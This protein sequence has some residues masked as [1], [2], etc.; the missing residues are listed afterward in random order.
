M[1]QVDARGL[2]EL[3][4]FTLRTDDGRDLRFRVAPDAERGEH[5]P[6][7]SHLREHMAYG[8]RILVR[9]RATGDELSA[10]AVVDQP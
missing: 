2:T 4:G 1:L 7:P 10:L 8:T 9:Y 6:T 5:R 3:D